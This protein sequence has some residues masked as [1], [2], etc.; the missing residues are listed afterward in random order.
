MAGSLS[1]GT[2]ILR[3]SS[4][5]EAMPVS[6]PVK[7]ITDERLGTLPAKPWISVFEQA[8]SDLA[9]SGPPWMRKVRREAIERFAALG[10]P[11]TRDE[12]WKFTNV[13]PLTKISFQRPSSDAVP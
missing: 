9:R 10:F 7:Q 4:R 1:P 6:T 2:R 13:A 3:W 12:E 8:E 5:R 11:T